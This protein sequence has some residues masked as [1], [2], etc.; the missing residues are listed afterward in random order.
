MSNTQCPACQKN[1]KE[2]FFYRFLCNIKPCEK[3]LDLATED[4]VVTVYNNVIDYLSLGSK[5]KL[6]NDSTVEVLS[7]LFKSK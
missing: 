2:D 6:K 7:A 3:C 4:S 5:P 1:E